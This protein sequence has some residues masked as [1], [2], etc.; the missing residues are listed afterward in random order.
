VSWNLVGGGPQGLVSANSQSGFSFNQY[1]IR[2]D[3]NLLSLEPEATQL[4]YYSGWVNGDALTVYP[5]VRAVEPVKNTQQNPL[6]AI[7]Q[8][9]PGLGP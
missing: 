1:A 2:G 6:T 8:K 7:A 3:F 4:R 5:Q 9:L